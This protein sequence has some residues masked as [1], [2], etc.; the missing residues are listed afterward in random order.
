MTIG[1]ATAAAPRP[2]PF[3]HTA[4][5]VDADG[6][7]SMLVSDLRRSVALYDE[8]LVVVGDHTRSVLTDQG[9]DVA[10]AVRWDDVGK[11]YQR[12]GFAYES[13]RRYLADAHRARRRVHVVAEPDLVTGVDAA[14]RADRAAA[15]L[16]YEAMCNHTYALGGAAVTCV[17]DSRYHPESVLRDV[18]T[19]HSHELTPAGRVPSSHYLPPER[20]LAD[21][22]DTVM[23]PP[24][25]HVDH[26]ITVA[27]VAGLTDLRSTVS[28]WALGHRFAGEA[29]DDLMVAVIEVATNGLRHG[30]PPVRVRAWH[31]HDTLVVQCDDAGAGPIPVLAGYLR[32]D[33]LAAVAGGRG[34]WLARQLADVVTVDCVPGRTSVRLHFPHQVM[35]S[36]SA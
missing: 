35:T 21:H 4:F 11:H 2:S 10:A 18:R 9:G 33:P 19:T 16:A 3:V 23:R 5:V 24:P 7:L 25:A 26:D 32:P 30:G 29:L 31:H 6:D 22:R 1:A 17:W 27:E 12:L 36:A 13:F 34:L 14:L 8:V 20:Y 15:Y 28:G